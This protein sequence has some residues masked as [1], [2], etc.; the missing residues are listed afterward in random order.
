MGS[1][2][3]TEDEATHDFQA[4]HCI[5]EFMESGRSPAGWFDASA[6][7]DKRADCRLVVEWLLMEDA[8]IKAIATVRDAL[9]LAEAR[10][11]AAKVERLGARLAAL[12]LIRR[13][14][15]QERAQV[16]RLNRIWREQQP[17]PARAAA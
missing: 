1:G 4:W 7:A 17:A 2:K 16:E 13:R 3:L 10:A 8:A 11:D 14:V 12:Q 9:G 5:A 6:G 15:S